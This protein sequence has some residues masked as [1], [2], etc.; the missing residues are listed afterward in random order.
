LKEFKHEIR[1]RV[2]C[3]RRPRHWKWP[4]VPSFL[5]ILRNAGIIPPVS[6]LA[7]ELSMPSSSEAFPDSEFDPTLCVLV[8]DTVRMLRDSLRTSRDLPKMN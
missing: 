5:P 2:R 8:E 7:T 4:E 6:S 3:P 1:Q